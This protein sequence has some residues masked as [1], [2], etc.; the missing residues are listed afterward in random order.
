MRPPRRCRRARIRYPV[1]GDGTTPM[2]PSTGIR[3]TLARASLMISPLSRHCSSYT[4]WARTAPPHRGS[5]STGRLDAWG[6][7]TST[8][9]P[10]ANDRST[11]SMRTRTGSPGMAP[12]TSTTIPSWRASIRPPA[13]GFS[14]TSVTMSP[15]RIM[16]RPSLQREG[17]KPEP[18]AQHT[19]LAARVRGRVGRR[20]QTGGKRLELRRGL[21]PGLGK[22][23][24]PAAALACSSRLASSASRSAR[25][26]SRASARARRAAGCMASRVRTRCS[27]TASHASGTSP[28]LSDVSLTMTRS[29]C[30]ESDSR[31]RGRA[32][33][34]P[35]ASV[36]A[37]VASP[38]SA[39]LASDS[40]RWM[41]TA[42]LHAS[43]ASS[44]SASQNS[45][46]AGRRR[47]PLAFERSM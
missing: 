29:R 31:L 34:P 4:M 3:P 41:P 20:R 5:P 2:G 16:V 26:R 35:S 27:R 14:G 38:S 15:W 40:A 11:R 23:V 24:R 44:T 12:A 8:A 17:G 42:R 28:V 37:P 32:S 1:S 46:R 22:Q 10:K 25:M 19:I 43:K 36:P 39:S 18:L 13:A 47:S 9:H 30:V 21:T 45:M 7:T 6:S 33:A